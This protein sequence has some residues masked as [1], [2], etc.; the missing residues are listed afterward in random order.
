MV[1]STGSSIWCLARSQTFVL[2]SQY[3]NVKAG[4]VGHEDHV[5]AGQF[6]FE[7]GDDLGER[8]GVDHVGIAQVVVL[9]VGDGHAG[10]DQR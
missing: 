8:R 2:T 1:S 10:V 9:V 4:V 5:V 3:T 6:G 7:L